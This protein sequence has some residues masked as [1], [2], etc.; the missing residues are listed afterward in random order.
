MEGYTSQNPDC[1]DPAKSFIAG[2]TAQLHN[3]GNLSGVYGSSCAANISDFATISDIPD[4][5]WPAGG[6]FSSTQYDQYA[7]VWGNRCVPDTLWNNHQRIYQY[8]SGH[9]ETWGGVSL[10][11]DSNVIDGIVADV[12]VSSVRSTFKSQSGYDGRIL[13]SSE[14]SNK[15]GSLNS[16]A[17]TIFLG[18]NAQ[19]KQYRSILSFPT[20]DLPDNAVITNVTLKVKKQSVA[21]GG[22]PVNSF[23]GFTVDIKTGFFGSAPGLQASDFQAK[24]I[25][26]YGPFKPA[27]KNGWYTFN[28]TSAEA[29]INKRTT[30]GG[31]T[32]I[33]LRFKLDDNNNAV[34]N[35]LSLYSGNAPAAWRPQLV[36]EYYVP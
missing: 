8:T 6:G 32:Q 3:T 30:N 15:G 17:T 13:E 7:T 2:W 35:Y 21:G 26:S 28:L 27:L 25:Q 19:K 4:A 11:I 10:N 5:I 12:V 34:A 23:K 1:R 20:K 36:I 18:D 22:D 14:T 31:V 9:Q 29:A 33:R 16:G 24:A